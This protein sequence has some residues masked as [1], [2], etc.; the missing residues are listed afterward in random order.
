MVIELKTKSK[1]ALLMI[2]LAVFVIGCSKK[3]LSEPLQM[4]KGAGSNVARI[5]V[6][7]YGYFDLRLFGNEAE[8]EVQKFIDLASSGYYDGKTV[9]SVIEDYCI[10][11]G[12]PEISDNS[13]NTILNN[14]KHNSS[15]IL[16]PFNGALCYVN[17]TDNIDAGKVMIITADAEFLS[18]LEELLAYKKVTLSEYFEQAYG[19]KLSNDELELFKQYG[20]APWLYGHCTV[21]G[22]IYEGF[23]TLKSICSCDLDEESPYKPIEEILIDHIEIK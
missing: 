16:Y 17:E 20:G 9:F 4:T 13:G 12:N 21:F 2:I 7:D 11:F 19:T 14:S 22:Q 1:L 6:K 8:Q 23:D 10:Q 18:E 15:D 5:V 3:E